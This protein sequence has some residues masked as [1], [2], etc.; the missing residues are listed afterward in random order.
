MAQILDKYKVFNK[1]N[2]VMKL[3]RI[4]KSFICLIMIEIQ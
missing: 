4:L 1:L 2:T 3:R